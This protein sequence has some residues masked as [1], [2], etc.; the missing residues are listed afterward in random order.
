MRWVAFTAVIAVSTVCAQTDRAFGIET[1]TGPSGKLMH[2]SRCS[3]SPTACY[4]EASQACSGPYQVLDS[5]SKAGGLFADLLPGPVTW[6]YMTYQCGATNGQVASF[7]MRGR[8]YNPPQPRV[9]ANVSCNQI[10]QFV[11]C[12]SY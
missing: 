12:R 2:I 8:Q 4:Q 5:Y 10:G 7:P 1:I 9:P 6:Y 11:N 3:Q